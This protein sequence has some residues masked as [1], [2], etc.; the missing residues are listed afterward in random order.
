V[1]SP[2]RLWH[3]AEDRAI[4]ASA[5]QAIAARVRRAEL[6]LLP[7]EGHFLVFERWREI[8]AWLLE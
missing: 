2:V 3:G 4:P 6:T 7:A 1:R 5:A 8:L